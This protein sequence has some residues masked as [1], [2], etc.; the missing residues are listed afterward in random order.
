MASPLRLPCL[1]NSGPFAGKTVA[2][3]NRFF[4]TPAAHPPYA[5]T[6]ARRHAGTQARR[7]A[8]AIAAWA[9]EP[10]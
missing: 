3:H 4:R 2:S 8:G 6:Q 10:S 5:G 7:H 9:A 1:C